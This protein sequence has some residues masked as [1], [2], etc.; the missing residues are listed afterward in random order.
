MAEH[1][2]CEQETMQAGVPRRAERGEGLAAGVLTL[3]RQAGNRA[4]RRLVQSM[5]Q[6]EVIYA[7]G[8]TKTAAPKFGKGDEDKNPKTMLVIGGAGQNSGRQLRVTGVT[9][10]CKSDKWGAIAH[11]WA[12]AVPSNMTRQV[13]ARE[14]QPR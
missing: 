5:V 3:Q 4:V 1:A 12:G 13:E 14:A 10:L 2:A 11:F 9:F 6:R 8:A 7:E